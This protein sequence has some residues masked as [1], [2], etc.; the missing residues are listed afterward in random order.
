[1]VLNVIYHCQNP[2]ESQT[3]WFT[4]INLESTQKMQTQNRK[5]SNAFMKCNFYHFPPVC[6]MI[7]CT[8]Q[9]TQ[10]KLQISSNLY[11]VV[12][13]TIGTSNITVIRHWNILGKQRNI[14]KVKI[15]WVLLTQCVIKLKYEGTSRTQTWSNE[16]FI[17]HKRYLP[18]MFYM[19]VDSIAVVL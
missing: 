14:N 2:T 5:L 10:N 17:V 3:M 9:S 4:C 15:L 6:T 13:Y 8:D 11:F 16:S 12:N 19:V 1:M 18:A 7:S